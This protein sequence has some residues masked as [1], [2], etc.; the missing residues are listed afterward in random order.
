MRMKPN[1]TKPTICCLWIEDDDDDDD[2]YDDDDIKSL[3]ECGCG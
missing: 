1:R 2:S 3:Y